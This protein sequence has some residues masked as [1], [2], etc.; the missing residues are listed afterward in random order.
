DN[1][2]VQGFVAAGFGAALMPRLAAELLSGSLDLLPF[3]PALP[4]RIIALAWTRDL[5]T[6][7]CLQTFVA[8]TQ[9][10]AGKIWHD[11]AIAGRLD[12][13]A[14]RLADRGLTRRDRCI[15]G[16]SGS[17]PG[18]RSPRLRSRRTARRE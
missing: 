7:P 18:W 15:D 3:D 11:R 17:W 2:V 8:A 12:V 9:R 14:F 5:A 4:P 16:S 10:V 13:W 1:N 6:A